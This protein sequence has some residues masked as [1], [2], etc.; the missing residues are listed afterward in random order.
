V[1]D[2]QTEARA[3]SVPGVAART[4]H[5]AALVDRYLAAQLRGDRR[6]A[7][8]LVLEEGLG[9]GVSVADVHLGVIEPAQQEIGRRWQ[10]NEIS[11]A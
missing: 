7:L 4:P 2:P 8:R 1:S 10:R 9:R 6:E 5:A 3:A 11:I